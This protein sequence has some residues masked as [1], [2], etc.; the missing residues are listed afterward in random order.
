MLANLKIGPK[1]AAVATVTTI[2]AVAI[3]GTA[4]YVILRDTLEQEKLAKLTAISELKA[5]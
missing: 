5:G 3:S 2:V 1:I 4:S